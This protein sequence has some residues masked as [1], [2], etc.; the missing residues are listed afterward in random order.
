MKNILFEG[1]YSAIFSIYDENMNVIEDS[2]KKLIQYGEKNGLRGFYVCGNTGECTVLP[3]R[4]RK[5]MLECVKKYAS[6]SS[7][8][9][10][11]VGAGHLDDVVDLI[12]HANEIGVD[13]I[14]SLPPSLTAYYRANE[15][16][17]YYRYIASLSKVPVL[18]YVTSVLNCDL[19]EF[20]E[21]VMAI[22]NIVGLKM[23]IPDY[24]G[25]ERIK[26]VNGGDINVLN[27][28]DE[29]MLSGLVM[30]ADGAIG[31]SYNVMP[32][33]ACGIY[34]SFKAGNLAE[35]LNYQHRLNRY[36]DVYVGKSIVD[37]KSALRLIGIDPGYTVAPAHKVDEEMFA[38]FVEKLKANG[39]Y[40]LITK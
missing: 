37:W 24:Y 7:K 6:P 13:A 19:V 8:I 17:E 34:N 38:G 1:I 3:N 29:S 40:D 5:Q 9:I 26:T 20:T 30:G 27:G 15:I 21:K 22:D 39:S 2:V 16:V 4:T 36:I 23:S 14:A 32:D 33:Q 31:T 12:A 35:A 11:H 10:A 18:A 25:F 28:P